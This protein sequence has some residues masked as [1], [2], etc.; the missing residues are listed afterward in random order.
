MCVSYG[1]PPWGR[2]RHPLLFLFVFCCFRAEDTL[3][4]TH[5]MWS[6][7]QLAQWRALTHV[8]ERKHRLK[9]ESWVVSTAFCAKI[10]G[11]LLIITNMV[12]GVVLI[13]LMA[14]FHRSAL[15]LHIKVCLQI[16][17]SATMWKKWYKVFC[18]LRGS[19]VKSGKLHWKD[20]S[21][22][23][24]NYIFSLLP[25]ELFISLD[26]FGVS[27]LVLESHRDFSLI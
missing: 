16:S 2:L 23:N 5:C 20:S 17:G 8:C 25:V 3:V 4:N 11:A 22:Q 13:A 1:A 18:G 19:C 15:I 24:Q 27:C 12:F 26:C 9:S 10:V 14:S 7:S 21:P 6:S